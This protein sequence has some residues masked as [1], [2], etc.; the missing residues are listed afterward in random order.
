MRIFRFLNK[1]DHFIFLID[2]FFLLLFYFI[3]I[4]K[5]IFFFKK[6]TFSLKS[7]INF[8][9][10]KSF[11]DHWSCNNEFTFDFF[12]IFWIIYYINWFSISFFDVCR[13]S[14]ALVADRDKNVL[15]FFVFLNLEDLISHRVF[16]FS[17]RF[18]IFIS[19]Y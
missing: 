15:S 14:I 10:L 12:I 7:L 17:N 2:D 8:N 5:S 3:I 4:V 19:V 11:D 18:I 16:F 6:K 13:I 1:I 9:M